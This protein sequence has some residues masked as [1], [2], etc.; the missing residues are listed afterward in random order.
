ME[1]NGLG[2]LYP[3]LADADYLKAH[4]NSII[5][6]IRYGLQDTLVINGKIYGEPMPAI[7]TLDDVEI[8]NI[9]NYVNFMWPFRS[10]DF[11][12]REVKDQL[13]L[14]E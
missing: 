4:P 8:N 13:K 14:C 7:P 11:T 2:E 5:C 6:A 10:G 1:G 9:V 12:Y 3:P